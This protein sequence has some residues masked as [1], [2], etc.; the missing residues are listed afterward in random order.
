[1]INIIEQ[2]KPFLE[3]ET[4]D[5][6]YHLQI[7]QRRKENPD[8]STNH[9]TLMHYYI[10]SIEHLERVMPEVISICNSVNARGCINLNKRSFKFLAK[11]MLKKIPDIYLADSYR[12]MHRAYESIVGEFTSEPKESRKW[13]IDID[14][15]NPNDID[16]V[17]NYFKYNDE[18]ITIY[19][20]FETKNGQHFITSP[21]RI[22]R[23]SKQFPEHDVHKNNP[24]NL[25]IP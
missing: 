15:K 22:D 13:I 5:V 11:Q 19:D 17:F 18:S 8:M 20:I 25:Y 6:F 9:T 24:V 16:D 1:M 12:T 14:T 2:I 7:I 10:T 4:D 3:F 23:F 21:F